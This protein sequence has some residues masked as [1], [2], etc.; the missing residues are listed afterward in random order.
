MT[1]ARG[2]LSSEN[3][4]AI[5]CTTDKS[6]NPV[7]AGH[8]HQRVLQDRNEPARRTYLGPSRSAASTTS[9]RRRR[10]ERPGVR[11][12]SLERH[13]PSWNLRAAD[14]PSSALRSGT[15]VLTGMRFLAPD[16]RTPLVARQGGGV[17]S[18]MRRLSTVHPR[19]PVARRR[20]S[21]RDRHRQGHRRRQSRSGPEGR[22]WVMWQD[23]V[24]SAHPDE[25]GRHESVAIV[26]VRHRRTSS[27]WDVFGEGS[28]GRSTSCACVGARRA[29]DR[30]I[31]RC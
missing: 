6:G 23:S 22:L 26:T 5:R 1:P 3:T 20:P 9:R 21:D 15:E 25:Q 12:L 16:H 31:G 10:R 27:L 2:R 29:S 28:L 14:R 8:R 18:P 11:R 24:G 30:G 13:G 19:A 7:F 4:A 17:T